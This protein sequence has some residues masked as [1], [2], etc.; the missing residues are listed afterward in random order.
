MPLSKKGKFEDE[1][2]ISCLSWMFKMWLNELQLF[3]LL[4]WV[5]TVQN[6]FQ[7]KFK[8]LCIFSV[9]NNEVNNVYFPN[10]TFPILA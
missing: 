10:L 4:N 1:E 8:Q 6:C 9:Q 5:V 7:S 2:E 3:K